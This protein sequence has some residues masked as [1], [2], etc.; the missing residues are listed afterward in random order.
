M[1]RHDSPMRLSH[2]SA[3]RSF[4]AGEDTSGHRQPQTFVE[5]SEKIETRQ[6]N[7][8]FQMTR[9]GKW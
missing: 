7:E 4:Q 3:E 9:V 5:E 8:T 2:N 6:S 1:D